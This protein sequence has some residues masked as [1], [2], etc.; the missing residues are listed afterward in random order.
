MGGATAAASGAGDARTPAVTAN[1]AT[2]IVNQRRMPRMIAHRP[3]VTEGA[4]GAQEAQGPTPP[5]FSMRIRVS[6]PAGGVRRREVLAGAE[7]GLGQLRQ[8]L[9][10]TALD[11]ACRPGDRQVRGPAGRE[12]SDR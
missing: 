6:N 5:T 2:I 11:D 3:P 4:I 7:H 9:R 1:P 12:A 10:G 8:Q